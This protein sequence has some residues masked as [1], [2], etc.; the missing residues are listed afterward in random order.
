[1]RLTLAILLLVVPLAGCLADGGGTPGGEAP[2]PATGSFAAG[3]HAGLPPIDWDRTAAIDWWEDIATNY[4]KH[5]SYLPTN[6]ML[7]ERLVSDLEGL[8]LDVEVRAYP[9]DVQ[10][11]AL[12]TPATMLYAIIATKPGTT[13][14]DHRIGLVSHYDTE[15]LTIHGAYDDASGVALD[16]HLCKALAPVPMARTLACIFFDG[17]EQGLVASREYVEDV[18]LAGD[19]GYVYDLV[20]GYDM[21]GINWP[22]HAWKLYAMAGEL[23]DGPGDSDPEVSPVYPF[24]QDLLHGVL[25]L[26]YEGVEVLPD[27]HRNSD[28]RR[29]KEA[30][31]PILRFAG[32]RNATDYDQYHMPLDTV[33]HVYE[34]TQ[35]RPNFE[36][37]F[38]AIVEA[39]YAVALAFDRTD[40][41]ALHAAYGV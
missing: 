37:G 39:S 13:L 8:G 9:G 1:M 21:T 40:L 23:W 18:V 3:L 34:V 4:P 27:S 31:V 15:A 17:E 14:P 16:F 20:L 11:Q 32:G 22:G 12:D 2:E 29:F 28:E 35:G 36:A 24:A 5:D 38:G 25:G 33:E 19:E 10:G 30:G 41:D 7:R 26:P 6:T